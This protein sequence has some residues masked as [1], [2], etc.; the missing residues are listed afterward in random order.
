M[1]KLKTERHFYRNGAL[2]EESSFL[3]RELH[4]A[5]RTWH[6][7]GRLAAEEFYE[8]GRLHGQC[9]QWNLR[10]K[11]LGLFQM[12]H[13][14]GTQREWFANGQVQMEASTVAGKFT[15]RTRVWLQDGTL[16]A[17]QFA[18][19]NR[20]VT[21]T[22]YAIIA[23]KRRDL[24]RYPASQDKIK[25]PR[26]DEIERREFQLQVESLLTQRNRREA[27]A[28]LEAGAQK[29]SLG[30]FNFTQAR[31]LVK[32][33]Y[34]AGAQ[35]VL[36]VQIYDGK[37]GK[38]FSD[39]LLIKLPVEK[40]ARAAIRQLLTKLPKKLRAGVLPA[41]DDGAEFLFAGFA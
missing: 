32:K 37:S 36:A 5:H 41:Q 21:Q 30:L 4:G 12:K 35:S 13:G 22:A 19:E 16:V 10:G 2:R 14:T 11:L 15:G 33:I 27:A 25:F 23:A 28:W 38:Q 17:E 1:G 8:H 6:P 40:S 31:Q 7:N 24:P 18:V 3:G 20:N 9:R 29:R 26:E 39:A 34:E